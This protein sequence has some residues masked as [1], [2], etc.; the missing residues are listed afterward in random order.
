M[1]QNKDPD[2]FGSKLERSRPAASV[3]EQPSFHGDRQPR[4]AFRPGEV[5]RLLEHT[6][7]FMAVL[8]GADLTLEMANAAFTDLVGGHNCIGKP[9]REVFPSLSGSSVLEVLQNVYT[10]GEP[11]VGRGAPFTFQQESGRIERRYIDFVCQPIIGDEGAPSG[12]FLQGHDVTDQ[13]RTE[14]WLRLALKGGRIAAWERDLTT[15]HVTWS[16]NAGEV[17]GIS[18]G[19]AST[20]AKH[21]HHDD[22]DKHREALAQALTHG[23]P[24][25]LVVRFVKPDGAV[26]WIAHRAEVQS[27]PEGFKKLTG[28]TIDI[29]EQ[30]LAENELRRREERYRQ[31]LEAAATVQRSLLPQ[32]GTAGN[33]RFRGYLQPSSFVGGDSFNIIQHDDKLSFFLIDVCGHGAAAALVSVTAHRAVSEAARR[34]SGFPPEEIVHQVCRN[35]PDE[36]PYFTMIFGQIDHASGA[37]SLVQAGHPHP[38]L[39]RPRKGIETLGMGG[40]PIGI[41]AA[42]S[43]EPIP[44]FLQP[45][46][47]LLLYSDGITDAENPLGE[48]FSDERLLNLLAQRYRDG[49]D[50]L[51]QN[52][53]GHVVQWTRGAGVGDDISALLIEHV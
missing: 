12:V 3:G 8:R 49:A 33:I 43:Y 46:D 25:D 18:S 36:L 9:V 50:D 52:L 35:W 14:E 22:R 4:G 7:G 10:T 48:R 16:D 31:D 47:G 51:I 41:D 21:V 53:A 17:L 26:I 5:R 37:G 32:D 15:D 11:V 19:P 38:L 1:S 27:G 13:K 39:I 24:Y 34:N 30:V 40:L 44:F 2:F 6:P 42:A 20:F 28:I 23:A 29:T 45:G